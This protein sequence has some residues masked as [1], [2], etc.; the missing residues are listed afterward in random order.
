MYLCLLGHIIMMHFGNDDKPNCV[1]F[2]PA[3][4]FHHIG[5]PVNQSMRIFQSGQSTND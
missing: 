3:T 4:V 5:W 2:L 1:H